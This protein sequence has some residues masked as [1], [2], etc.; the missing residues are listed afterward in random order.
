MDKSGQGEYLTM[1]SRHF[2]LS[3]S[4]FWWSGNFF[5]TIGPSRLVCGTQGRSSCE[6]KKNVLWDNKVGWWTGKAALLRS[7]R[8][9]LTKK[10]YKFD[11]FVGIFKRIQ[12]DWT[13]LTTVNRIGWSHLLILCGEIQLR[14]M[15]SCIPLDFLRIKDLKKRPNPKSQS[16]KP[17]ISKFYNFFPWFGSFG[18]N[19]IG[20]AIDLS[21][22]VIKATVKPYIVQTCNLFRGYVFLFLFCSSNINK[23]KYNY[24]IGVIEWKY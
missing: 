8:K 23:G 15:I 22:K 2:K 18:V 12:M 20:K 5:D 24:P 13:V 11:I 10:E 16:P 7:R 21:L 14:Y 19:L 6:L 3:C 1:N 17:K 9:R 4:P